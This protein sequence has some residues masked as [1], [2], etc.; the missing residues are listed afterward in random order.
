[1]SEKAIRSKLIEME[2]A[3]SARKQFVEFTNKRGR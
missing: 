2:C 1:M 3:I